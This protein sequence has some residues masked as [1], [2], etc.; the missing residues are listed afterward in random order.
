MKSAVIINPKSA[1]GNTIRMWREIQTDMQKRLGGVEI[2]MTE[3]PHHGTKIAQKLAQE[4][5]DRLIIMGGDGSIHE[6]INGLV[7]AS[8][9]AISKSIKIGILNSGRGCD[10]VRTLDIPTESTAAIGKLADMRTKPIDVG[11]VKIKKGDRI[12]THYFINSF[13]YGLGGEVARN[14][15]RNETNLLTPKTTYFVASA[16]AFLKSKPFL[17]EFQ[18]ANQS[19]IQK[20]CMNLFAMNGRF[21]GGGMNWAPRGKLDDGLLDLVVVEKM[22]KYKLATLAPKVYDGT[23]VNVPGVSYQ[24]FSKLKIKAPE[25]FWIEMDG[26]VIQAKEFELSVLPGALNFII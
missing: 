20:E 14:I 24:Q 7:D 4:N 1:G 26:E 16:W 23:F 25:E 10:F 6:A 22:P 18:F 9:N 11:V 21:S 12:D 17:L 15:Q 19:S 8:G 2:F 13:S 3:Y 5:Y